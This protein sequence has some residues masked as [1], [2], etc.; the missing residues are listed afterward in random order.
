MCR[1]FGYSAA[2]PA[3]FASLLGPDLMSS[4]TEL[5]K[6]HGDGWGKAWLLPGQD[7]PETIKRPTSA[8][9]DTEFLALA[10]EVLGGS[11]FVH[12]RWATPGLPHIPQNTHPF[13]HQGIAFAHTGAIYPQADLGTMLKPS[14]RSHLEGTTDSEHYFLA[15]LQDREEKSLDLVRGIRSAIARIGADFEPT[16]LNC[17]LVNKDELIAVNSHH[18]DRLPEADSTPGRGPETI[19]PDYFEVKWRKRNGHVLVTSM[20]PP[21]FDWDHVPNGHALVVDRATSETRLEEVGL[22][23]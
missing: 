15:I 1:F 10:E 12:L 21:F 9:T 17:I 18:P 3:S 16:G 23:F 20:E 13:V 14:W 4:F 2:E 22:L 6:A 5:A 19:P 11:G 7:G 8:A